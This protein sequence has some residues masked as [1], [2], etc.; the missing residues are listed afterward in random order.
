MDENWGNGGNPKL[1]QALIYQS[2]TIVIAQSANIFH[3][4]LSTGSL[5]LFLSPTHPRNPE[6]NIMNLS[7]VSYRLQ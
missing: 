2:S 5:L 3:W 7:R 4:S 6:S 1:V